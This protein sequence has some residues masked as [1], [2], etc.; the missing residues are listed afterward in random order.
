MGVVTAAAADLAD[1]TVTA[2]GA[3]NIEVALYD[4]AALPPSGSP[5]WELR[6]A[7]ANTT[8]PVHFSPKLEFDNG[9]VIDMTSGVGY[10]C[11]AYGQP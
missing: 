5:K 9:I 7:T 1:L 8:T 2:T 3:G 11:L 10:A 4:L 6:V